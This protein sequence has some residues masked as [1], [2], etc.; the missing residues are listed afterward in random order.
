MDEGLTLLYPEA[1]LRDEHKN[2]TDPPGEPGGTGLR[3][4]LKAL[5]PWNLI[6]VMPAEGRWVGRKNF[7]RLPPS[8]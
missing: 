1:M 8:A 4:G 3:G 2:P 7:L 6:R 5:D